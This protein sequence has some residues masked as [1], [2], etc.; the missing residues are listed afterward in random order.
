[1]IHQATFQTALYVNTTV[2]NL[3][4]SIG[5]FIL[6]KVKY[7]TYA[8]YGQQLLKNVSKQLTEKF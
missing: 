7:T 4:W 1:L 6:S 2:N 5:N 8:D 3:Y